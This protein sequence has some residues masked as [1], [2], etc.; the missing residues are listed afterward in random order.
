ML[1]ANAPY[2]QP[3]ALQAGKLHLGALRAVPHLNDG[4]HRR[5]LATAD[6]A[7][8]ERRLFATTERAPP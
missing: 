5:A 3:L 6:G 2:F 8:V 4:R 1:E 7:I